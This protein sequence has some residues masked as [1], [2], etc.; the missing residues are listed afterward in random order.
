MTLEDVSG[1]GQASQV[2]KLSCWQQQE[3]QSRGV[4]DWNVCTGASGWVFNAFKKSKDRGQR[5]IRYMVLECN[6]KGW[7]INVKVPEVHSV[8]E[9]TGMNKT[10]QY[11]LSPEHGGSLTLNG[12]NK[13]SLLRSLRGGQQSRG[14]PGE[15][16]CAG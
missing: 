14:K 7:D 12:Y 8:S 5:V 3:E 11:Q 16:W 2:P 4:C 1:G 15:W 6:G 10:V 9:A 13:G